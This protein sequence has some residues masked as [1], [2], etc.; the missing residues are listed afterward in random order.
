[1]CKFQ[2]LTDDTG[3]SWSTVVVRTAWSLTQAELR[4]TPPPHCLPL[5]SSTFLVPRNR[6]ILWP[7]M[8]LRQRHCLLG[9]PAETLLALIT[10]GVQELPQELLVIFYAP[11]IQS[12]R[13]SYIS[14]RFGSSMK[15]DRNRLIDLQRGLSSG[16]ILPPS[17]TCADLGK[18]KGS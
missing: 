8:V 9:S 14:V 7:E 12:V 3:V 10:Q 13:C 4:V 16:L 6:A 2:E 18:Q 11:I 17:R 5:P 1:M 15:Q